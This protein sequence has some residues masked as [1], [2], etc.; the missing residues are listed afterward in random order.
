[1]KPK[2]IVIISG[3]GGTGK[4]TITGAFASLFRNKVIADCDVDAPD[5]WIL[6]SPSVLEKR[7]FKGQNKFKILQDRCILCGECKEVCRFNAVKIADGVYSIYEH[8]CDG[9]G[10]C[11]E[12]CPADAV[13]EVE[14]VAGEYYISTTEKGYF[15]HAKLFAAEENTGK[16]VMFVRNEAKG[17]AHRY[18]IPLVLIDGP[19]GTGCPVISS[20]TGTDAV[21][22]VTEPTVSGLHDLKRI[23]ELTVHFNIKPYVVVNKYNLSITKT[24]EIEEYLKNNKITYLGRIEF[25]DEFTK[26]LRHNKDIVTW[27]KGKGLLDLINV[28]Q[29][30]CLYEIVLSEVVE[31]KEGKGADVV[32]AESFD[33]E[34]VLNLLLDG[35]IP[36]RIKEK[37]NVEKFMDKDFECFDFFDIKEKKWKDG[38]EFLNPF[39]T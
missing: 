39:S 11:Y 6:L 35:K 22:V 7:V 29:R 20:I 3:K 16:L 13:K 32:F 9:C 23:I 21:V 1:M 12:V 19:P 8:N 10:F 30:L 25:D 4:T 18:N 37:N 17:I 14:S 38:T 24:E 27:G 28:W 36:V 34:E 2:E 26:A 5:L 15:V 31:K 33:T